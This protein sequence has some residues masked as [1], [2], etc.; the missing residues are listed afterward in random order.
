MSICF[1]FLSSS[2][3]SY[4][5][6]I[7]ISHKLFNV[8]YMKLFRHKPQTPTTRQPKPQIEFLR[9][10]HHVT[11]S[12]LALLDKDSVHCNSENNKKNNLARRLMY[13][14]NINQVWLLFKTSPPLCTWDTHGGRGQSLFKH[15]SLKGWQQSTALLFSQSG[16][17]DQN[18]QKKSERCNMIVDMM[19]YFH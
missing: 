6:S 2:Y 11:I 9:K 16:L 7:I 15:L 5:V 8:Q 17:Y 10:H 14:R 1:L 19:F 13:G 18:A 4:D 12:S 3:T